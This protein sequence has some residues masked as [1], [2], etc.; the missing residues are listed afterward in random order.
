MSETQVRLV[1]L[2]SCD[3]TAGDFFRIMAH[4]G[5]ISQSSEFKQRTPD[6]WFHQ[7][8]D[9]TTGNENIGDFLQKVHA[10]MMC[11]FF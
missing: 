7:K 6:K 4:A 2:L 3:V 8:V 9:K 10:I 1:F 5:K 11:V